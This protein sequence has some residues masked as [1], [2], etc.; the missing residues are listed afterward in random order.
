MN[1]LIPSVVQE[2][3]VIQGKT[4][5]QLMNRIFVIFISISLLVS[6][7]TSFAQ[8]KELNKNDLT[9]VFIEALK[10][11]TFGNF[12]QAAYLLQKSID[13]NPNCAACYY[14][15]SNLLFYANDKQNAQV[16]ASKA[17][18]L[19]SKNYW[20]C[21]NV[22]DICRYNEANSKAE[23]YYVLLLK[24]PEANLEDKFNY[25]L[26]LFALNKGKN[27]LSILN[28]IENEYGFSEMI[29]LARYRYF[30]SQKKYTDAEK[31]LQLLIK[32]FPENITLYG[33]LAEL[34][35]IEKKDDLATLNYNKLLSVDSLSVSGLI[36]YARFSSSRYNYEKSEKL[37]N[38][39]FFND[40]ISYTKK[41]DALK[42]I[43]K[44]EKNSFS[45]REYLKKNFYGI[46]SQ[47][48]KNSEIA[49]FSIDYY[50]K[51]ADYDSALAVTN[52]LIKL[53]PENP[54][55]LDRMFF[56]LNVL[57]KFDQIA[58]MSDSIISKFSDRSFIYLISGIAYNQIGN[59]QKS[60]DLL[61]RGY[62]IAGENEFLK[63]QFVTFL[64]EGFIKLNNVDSAFYYFELAAGAKNP[65][66]M[67]LNN[68]AYYLSENNRDLDK[69]LRMSSLT[70]KKE[71][72]NSTYLD[73]YAWILY[74]KS[75]FKESLKF[76]SLAYKNGGDKDK[77]ILEHYG[78]ILFCNGKNKKAIEF[79]NMS[80]AVGGDSIRI[81]NKI[82]SFRCGQ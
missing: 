63:E 52:R 65:S 54:L 61:A 68:Y 69:A 71:P 1:C 41:L 24:M 26:V 78:D 43:F 48:L 27:A 21:K 64:A 58:I 82:S 72:K 32:F 20:Y 50:E 14:E 18:L 5:N 16:Y 60:V 39:I 23:E 73:T 46:Q 15:L 49:E 28:S 33:M 38:K 75:S 11:K 51:V 37:Y 70:L 40:S 22:A 13:I 76:I 53:F 2:V 34:Y 77:D 17:F 30:L 19:D 29:S 4:K 6:Y 55:Y 74:R 36:S 57:R 80:I 79:W 25:A 31:E 66:V 42:E 56:Y 8:Q 81:T 67:L 44:D 10:S 45:H 12:N 59:I 35:A 47:Y 7:K 3:L 9:Y 62:S